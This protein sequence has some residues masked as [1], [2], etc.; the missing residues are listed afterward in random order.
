M[1]PDIS[2]HK[3]FIGY[4]VRKEAALQILK[5]RVCKKKVLTLSGENETKFRNTYLTALNI[6]HLIHQEPNFT[7]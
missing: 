5:A 6:K 2:R 7:E 4:F 1:T 3:P